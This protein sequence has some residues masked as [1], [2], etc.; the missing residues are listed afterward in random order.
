[1]VTANTT[2]R[3]EFVTRDAESRLKGSS[4][5]FLRSVRCGYDEGRLQ[6]DGNVPTFY[7]KQLAQSLVQGVQGVEQIDNRLKVVCATGVSDS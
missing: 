6:L 7:L 5:L 4:H 3:E 1:M 2:V